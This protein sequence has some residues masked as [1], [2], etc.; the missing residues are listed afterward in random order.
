M[1]GCNG[2]EDGGCPADNG[3]V[4]VKTFEARNPA[5]DPRCSTAAGSLGASCV[6][7]WRLEVSKQEQ[8]RCEGCHCHEH[9]SE[10]LIGED[11][12]EGYGD[13]DAKG[14]PC[15]R[16]EHSEVEQMMR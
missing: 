10:T 12:D 9:P 15:R 2:K 1:K 11:A 6:I 8:T 4:L 14:I 5:T 13:E 3:E 7:Y 16:A